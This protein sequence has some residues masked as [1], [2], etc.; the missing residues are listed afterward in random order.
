MQI[1]ERFNLNKTQAELDFI[2]IDT[3]RD[4]PLFLAPSSLGKEKT[5]GIAEAKALFTYLKE[6]N[7]T[8][9]GMSR[10]KPEGNGVGNTD[11]FQIFDNLIKS[12]AI[13]TGLIQDLEDNV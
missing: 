10:G 9:L 6:P 1:S 12:R 3:D 4:I 7:A 11:R 8:C 13:Q 2:D 5:N